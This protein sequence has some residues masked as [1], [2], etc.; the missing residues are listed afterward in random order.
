MASGRSAVVDWVR[1]MWPPSSLRATKHRAR[2]VP[3]HSAMGEGK[4]ISSGHSGPRHRGPGHVMSKDTV[5][6][7]G[8]RTQC[9]V[10]VPGHRAKSGCQDTVPG[11]GART[12]CQVRVPGHCARSGYQ[13]TVPG[14]GARTQV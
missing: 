11:Q 4:D 7:Q 14:Q 12:Q 13:D 9:Q 1:F 6:G 5:S 3:R 8:A 2:T 10:R